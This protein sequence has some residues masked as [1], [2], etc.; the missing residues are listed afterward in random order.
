MPGARAVGGSELNCCDTILHTFLWWCGGFT[1]ISLLRAGNG[2]CVAYGKADWEVRLDSSQLRPPGWPRRIWGVQTK[3]QAVRSEFHTD[4][5]RNT[6]TGAAGGASRVGFVTNQHFSS[7][8]PGGSGWTTLA[9][10]KT[11]RLMQI[12]MVVKLLVDG[13][14]TCSWLWWW[15]WAEGSVSSTPYLG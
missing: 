5:N 9:K 11:D 7:Q 13:N 15:E 3:S 8:R 2:S 1:V 4:Q 12:V 10:S 6:L 14:F